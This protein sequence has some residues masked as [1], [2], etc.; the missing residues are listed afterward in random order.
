MTMDRSGARR[1]SRAALLGA[2]T[3]LALLSIPTA[4]SASSGASPAAGA[5][6]ST[7]RTISRGNLRVAV[8]AAGYGVVA[9]ARTVDGGEQVLQVETAADGTVRVIAQPTNA[10]A[11][12]TS[13]FGPQARPADAAG[14]VPG[15]AA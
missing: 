8:P 15:G 2:L 5:R 12:G 6:A 11:I 4:T 14:F 13:R 10:A 7:A 1:L 3:G 9:T